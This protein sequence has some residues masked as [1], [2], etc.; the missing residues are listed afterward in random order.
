MRILL[1]RTGGFTG[2]K[3]ERPL[4]SST[5]SAPQ[6]RRLKELLSQSRFFEFPPTLESLHPSAD[7]FNCRLTVE[8]GERKHPVEACETAIPGPM[9]ALLDFLTRS[10]AAK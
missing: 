2:K 8:S 4:D 10:L 3:L 1:E 6:A 5:L 7:H 9:R